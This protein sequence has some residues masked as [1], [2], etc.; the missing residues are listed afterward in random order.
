MDP[1]TG[2]HTQ[3]AE[4][5]NSI[6]KRVVD[7]QVLIWVVLMKEVVKQRL[8]GKKYLVKQLFNAV[9][10]MVFEYIAYV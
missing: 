6:K 10:N 9:L 7:M 5:I 2:A 1:I 4:A 3:T 8:G